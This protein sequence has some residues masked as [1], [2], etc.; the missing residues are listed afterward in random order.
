MK[1]HLTGQMRGALLEAGL[2]GKGFGEPG[3]VLQSSTQCPL[4]RPCRGDHRAWCGEGGTAMGE[5]HG[6]TDGLVGQPGA[7]PGQ[8]A[9]F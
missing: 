3:A 9:C 6:Q 7:Q 4:P 1:L 2:P 8:E 5:W